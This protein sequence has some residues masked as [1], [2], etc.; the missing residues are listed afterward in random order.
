[1]SIFIDSRF[2]NEMR[3]FGISQISDVVKRWFLKEIAAGVRS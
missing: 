3:G 1:M 2:V